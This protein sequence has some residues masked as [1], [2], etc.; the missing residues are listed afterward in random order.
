[1]IHVMQTAARPISDG[2]LR[3]MFAARKSVFVDLL[4]WDVPVIDGTYEVD[5]FDDIH[6]TY[7][8]LADGEGGH[9]ASARLLP[10][11]RPHILDSFYAE[12]C[13]EAPP[14]APDVFEIT[15]FC[16]DRGL[17]ARERRAARDTLVTALAEHALA[18]GIT[19]YTAIAEMPWFQQILAFGW[20]CR[21]LGLPQLISGTM[22]VALRIEIDAHTLAQLAAAGIVPSIDLHAAAR[23][24][25]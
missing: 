15:R 9:L 10:T 6:A 8:V 22:L 21:P 24:A 7:L 12:L 20:R 19:A 18:N 1:M 4:K 11:T 3:A 23:V 16:L 17:T 2:V 14:Q 13:E 5:Q 25:A